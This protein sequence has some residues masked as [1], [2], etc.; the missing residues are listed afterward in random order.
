[1]QF[2]AAR[3]RHHISSHSVRERLLGWLPAKRHR[4]ELQARVK[5]ALVI[6][7]GIRTVHTVPMQL[8]CNYIPVCR[9]QAIALPPLSRFLSSITPT[10]PLGSE[11]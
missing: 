4:L 6:K 2:K 5:C 7:Q 8:P 10:R 3:R 1:M 9:S 11:I